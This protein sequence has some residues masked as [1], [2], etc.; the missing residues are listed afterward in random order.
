MDNRRR[1]TEEFRIEAVRQIM[2]RGAAVKDVGQ[3]L[4]FSPCSG[5]IF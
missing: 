3:R 5:A 4:G 1:F 2:E